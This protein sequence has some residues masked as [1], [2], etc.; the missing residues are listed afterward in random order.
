MKTPFHNLPAPY[1]A[2]ESK[3]YVRGNYTI[4]SFYRRQFH[5]WGLYVGVGLLL[6]TVTTAAF[7][8]IWAF[9]GWLLF[10]VVAYKAIEQVSDPVYTGFS[11]L[12]GTET[13]GMVELIDA[14]RSARAA[15]RSASDREK[16]E[17]GELAKK[18]NALQQVFAI[19]G[20]SKEQLQEING[21]AATLAVSFRALFSRVVDDVAV[22]PTDPAADT[23]ALPTE[24]R[25]VTSE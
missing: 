23:T 10:A 18:S 13:D 2:Y 5:S 21:K 9:L 15:L 19:D 24:E 22:T 11:D 3:Y 16:A 14:H 12:N 8:P 6:V 25:N 7:A 17:F 4:R 1:L 20:T